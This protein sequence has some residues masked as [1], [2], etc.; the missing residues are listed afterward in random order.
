LLPCL[1]PLPIFICPSLAACDLSQQKLSIRWSPAPPMLSQASE[2]LI[3]FPLPR[4]FGY[5]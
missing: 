3:G 4:E 2:A 1:V 5:Q